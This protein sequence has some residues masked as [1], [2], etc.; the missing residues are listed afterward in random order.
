MTA[1]FKRQA[2]ATAAVLG[3]IALSVALASPANAWWRGGFFIGVPGPFVVAPPLYAPPPV[4][5]TPPV[6]APPPAYAQPG[7]QPPGGYQESPD[8]YAQPQG[9]YPEY[10]G[11]QE[12]SAGYPAAPEQYGQSSGET[13]QSCFAGR[14]VCPLEHALPVG[15][16][17]WC[18]GNRGARQWGQ[19]G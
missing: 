19:A 13:A 15:G 9:G 16:K 12:P 3:G 8:Q 10:P 11:E 2:L 4:Y 5:A 18:P 14:Y 1:R 7:E 6:Y 17:C